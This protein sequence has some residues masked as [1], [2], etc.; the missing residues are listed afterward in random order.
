MEVISGW[1]SF[2]EKIKMHLSDLEGTF[3]HLNEITNLSTANRERIQKN[4][5]AK[6]QAAV[7]PE[8]PGKFPIRMLPYKQNPKFYGRKAELARINN[9]LDWKI[10]GNNPLRTYT[11]YGRRGVGKTQLALQYAYANPANFDAIFW[12]ACETSL[13]L[14]QSFT[15][16]ANE[17]KLPG[18]NKHGE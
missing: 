17:I 7:E 6:H 12:V 8:E 1:A 11:I 3:K 15:D 10:E 9:A 2:D 16:M 5:V 18:A 13:Y 4:L 14:R